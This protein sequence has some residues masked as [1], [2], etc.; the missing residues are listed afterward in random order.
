MPSITQRIDDYLTAKLDDFIGTT[1]RL[2][3]QPSVSAR[4]E[5]THECAEL[6]AQVL[7]QH[8]FS[9]RKF[10][11]P[12]NPILLAHA[13]G[14]TEKTLLFYNHYDVQPPEPL[15]LWTTPPY[16]PTIRDGALYARGADDDKGEFVARLAGILAAKEAN[17]GK[18][19]CGI[20]FVVEGEEEIGSP[21]IVQFV[22]EH[23]NLLESLAA[24][25]EEGGIDSSGSPN[26]TLG[27]RG[28]LSVEL[29]VKVLGRD[30]HSG[31]A[32]ILP[33]AA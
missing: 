9:V 4:S 3:A 29:H 10:E 13:D 15:E 18:L 28:L 2:C 7:S 26:I 27:G 19:P 33:N 30:A 1:V 24:I 8:A 32:H 20:T 6:V 12:G 21:H 14:E 5:G 11:T 22:K 25:W 17:G 31:A 23:S 16:Q